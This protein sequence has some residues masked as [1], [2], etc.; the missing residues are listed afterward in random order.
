M[1]VADFDMGRAAKRAT[2]TK[3]TVSSDAK[4]ELSSLHRGI[5]ALLALN[6][7]ESV[8]A[9]SLALEL[10][11]SRTTAR[12]ILDTLVAEGV[13]EKVPYETI[14]RLSPNVASLA[15]GVSDAVIISHIAS[16]LLYATTKK[17][18]WG[19]S[20]GTLRGDDLVIQVA[21]HRLSPFALTQ[22]RVGSKFDIITSHSAWMIVA[23]MADD[24][25]EALLERLRAN[26][27]FTPSLQM[28]RE[29]IAEIQRRG[30]SINPA[31]NSRQSIVCVPVFINGQAKACLIM[32]YI[33]TAMSRKKIESDFVPT[34]KALAA[35]IEQGVL[36][37]RPPRASM[38][39]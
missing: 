31:H 21:T 2:V 24:E 32:Q 14:Y 15:S 29:P 23:F 38:P 13:A 11:L 17:I 39:T 9:S 18:G 22:L 12:R 20:I 5:R 10:G 33:T 8:K 34:L 35:D 16:P 37:M 1:A 27:R 28:V 25:R 7:N 19:L 26:P 4:K 30:F 6:A 36:A 3:P